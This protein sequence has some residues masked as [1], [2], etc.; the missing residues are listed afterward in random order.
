MNN[1]EKK[2]ITKPY[3]SR[4]DPRLSDFQRLAGYRFG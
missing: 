1:K 3:I 4:P 2:N